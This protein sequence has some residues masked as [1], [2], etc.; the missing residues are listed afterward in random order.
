MGLLKNI[1][2]VLCLSVSVPYLLFPLSCSKPCI[3]HTKDTIQEILLFDDNI[4]S[5]PGKFICKICGDTFVDTVSP[6]D[7][8]VPIINLIGSLDDVSKDEKKLMQIELMFPNEEIPTIHC[9]TQIKLQGDSSI[10]LGYPKK[11]FNIQLYKSGTDKK[12]KLQFKNWPE[13]NKFTLK[14][15]YTDFSESRNIATASI[16]GDVIH[17]RKVGDKI[18]SLFNGGAID[19]FPIALYNND[20]FHGLYTLNVPKE[21]QL[22]DMDDDKSKHEAMF[23]SEDYNES[24]MFQK[25][26][27]S[28]EDGCG[29][30]VE[31]CST[32][33]TEWIKYSFN[34]LINFVRTST[35]EQFK[36]NISNYIDLNRTIDY[37]CFVQFCCLNDNWAKNIIWTTYDGQKWTPGAYDL[38]SSF[39]ANWDGTISFNYDHQ[40]LFDNHILFHRIEENFLSQIRKQYWE[41][42]GESLKTDKI[43]EHFS[44][45]INNIGSF[46]YSADGKRWPNIFLKDINHL[47]QI[48]NF[49]NQRAVWLDSIFK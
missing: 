1:K 38:D 27:V 28:L 36:Q 35:D 11:N 44:N 43:I 8:G 25:E 5:R 48:T 16:F 9:D 15:N 29:W 23:F 19:G 49:I 30:D 45:F 12:E 47:E 22:Y 18:D 39:G 37:M 4:Q 24:T 34:Q 32:Q 21:K 31:F 7:I 46:L 33:D 10:R 42:R 6:Q 17:Q 13:L 40:V 3:N 20:S 2:H 41:L 26:I 14:A